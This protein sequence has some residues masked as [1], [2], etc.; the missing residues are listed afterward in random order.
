M[1]LTGKKIDSQVQIHFTN[2]YIWHIKKLTLS[3]MH[4]FKG[5]FTSPYFLNE[6]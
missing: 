2:P 4:E 1:Q 5:L 6:K 3:E